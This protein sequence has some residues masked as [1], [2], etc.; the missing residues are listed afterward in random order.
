MGSN[1]ALFLTLT[2]VATPVSPAAAR[3]ETETDA[4]SAGGSVAR[5][6]ETAIG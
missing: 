4:L 6:P 5:R 2:L 3:Y 1:T